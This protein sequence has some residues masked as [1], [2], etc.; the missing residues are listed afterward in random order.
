MYNSY[1]LQ[2]LPGLGLGIW[3]IDPICNGIVRFVQERGVRLKKHTLNNKILAFNNS[4]KQA[5]DFIIEGIKNNYP[6]ILLVTFNNEITSLN[7]SIMVDRHFVTIT[8][9]TRT[10]SDEEDYELTVSNWGDRK[11]LPSLKRMWEGT[12]FLFDRVQVANP[13]ITYRIASVSLG[14]CSFMC[15]FM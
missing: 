8:A 15:S 9:I 12:P 3:S 6:I 1:T 10:T 13:I 11:T 5:A 2:T 7:D 14:Y 4:F